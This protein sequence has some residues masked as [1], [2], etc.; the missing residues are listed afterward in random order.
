MNPNDITLYAAKNGMLR[1]I[2]A[3]RAIA[4][5]SG[6]KLDLRETKAMVENIALRPI[7]VNFTSD[8]RAIV[9]MVLRENFETEQEKP[10]PVNLSSHFTWPEPEPIRR[11]FDDSLDCYPLDSSPWP[12]TGE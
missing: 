3:L 7:V 11:G 2:K 10:L 1:A 12:T 8:E 5:L 4:A 6:A 9:T